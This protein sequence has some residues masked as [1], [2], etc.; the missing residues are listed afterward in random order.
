MSLT[1]V[2]GA[3]SDIATGGADPGTTP[4]VI[5]NTVTLIALD[6]VR[7]AIGSAADVLEIDSRRQAVG[8]VTAKAEGG[9]FLRETA[10]DL[11][12][13]AILSRTAD[14]SLVTLSGS[15]LDATPNKPAID[16]TWRANIQGRS[17]DL[18]ATGGSI[19]TAAD[20]VDFY[21]A[22]I[23]QER[24]SFEIDTMAVPRRGQLYA[25]A[26]QGV[27]LAAMNAAVRVAALV[28]D[29]GDASLS[30]FD[31]VVQG[32]DVYLLS[33]S[34]IGLGAAV[35][36]VTATA[37]S[38]TISA[39]DNVFVEADTLVKAGVAATIRG[40]A[41][42]SDPDPDNGTTIDVRGDVQAPQ[43]TIAGGGDL[44]FLE[45]SRPGGINATNA[46]VLEGNGADDRFF[47]QTVAGA[48]SVK[49]VRA[50]TASTFRAT[51]R[52]DCS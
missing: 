46:T 21:G 20:A 13:D 40:D 24:N 51:R 1:A 25:R 7:G 2:Q 4:W 44:D 47:I 48:M 3:I 43:V 8:H 28:A 26:S 16:R 52:S 36:R 14:V 42:T 45:I 49:V 38:V 11:E 32:E 6:A 39:G 23:G 9:V 30:V 41:A 18:D 12:L 17:I 10:G 33:P 50:R 35:G 27:N 19:G 5:G 29:A 34:G 22:G 31:S 15:I 37:G